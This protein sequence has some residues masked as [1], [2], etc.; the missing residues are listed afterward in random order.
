MADADDLL[1]YEEDEQ[2]ETVESDDKKQAKKEVKGNYVSIHSSGFRDFLLKPEI[3]RA[4]VDCGFEHPSEVQHECIPQAMLGMDILCQAKSGM[5]KT[6]VFVLSTLQQLEVYES[7]VYALVLCHTRELAFQISKEFERFTKY[8]PAVKVSVFFGGVPITKDED[9]LKNN[10]PHVV[11]GTPGRILE[12]I[13]KKKLVLN[14]LKHFI[15]DECDKMLEIL[16]MRSDVQ[17]IFKN[18]PFNKQVMMFSATLSKD[19]RPVCKKF[20]QQPLEVYVDDDAKLSLHGLQQYYVK[21]TEKEK[22]KKL[23]DLLD[24]LEFNQVIIF[25]KS[26]QRCVV[27]TELLNE[28][29]FPSVAMHGGMSQQDRLKF[30]QEFKDFQKRI[31]VATNLFGR[32]MDIERV[33]IVINYDMPEDTDTYLHRVAR[34][35][36]FGTKGLAITFI[37]EETDAKVL[38]SVQ[39]RFDVTIGRM[40][41][42]IELSSYVERK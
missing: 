28:Q 21:L 7:E 42:E 27:L 13:R 3:L 22:N 19:I 16:H 18:T 33:N 6:A 14:N 23:F 30:Y 34:A 24:E 38:N 35:G 10:K 2:N 31:L 40:P 20:M 12:L 32:G 8:L 25:V 15:L 39:D 5:G 37:C 11:V 17:E 29:N 1:D 9:T 26:V 36:R 41:N 4:I